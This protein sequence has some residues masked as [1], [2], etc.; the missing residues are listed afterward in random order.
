MKF[1]LSNP[2][3]NLFLNNP[4]KGFYLR[5]ISKTIKR[6]P[7]LLSKE[8]NNYYKL[9]I[10]Q[11]KKQA[12]TRIYTLNVNSEFVKTLQKLWILSEL[13]P[14]VD[15]LKEDVD[16]IILY[17]SFADQKYTSTSD[18]D[19]LVLIDT[20][21]INQEEVSK[22]EQKLNKEISLITMSELEYNRKLKT[23]D[24]FI[25]KV[26]NKGIIIYSREINE[27]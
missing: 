9:N 7:S 16:K 5:E 27:F 13:K 25:N 19:L 18:I 14:I 23:K 3:L 12:N 22:L 24:S 20:K 21:K 8:L 6:N 15:S 17:G 10:L 2:T 11:E 4:E 1:D 26:N